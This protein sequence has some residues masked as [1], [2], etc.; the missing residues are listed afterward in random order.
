MLKIKKIKKIAC[1]LM[2]I[3]AIS[4]TGCGSKEEEVVPSISQQETPPVVEEIIPEPEP[5]LTYLDYFPHVDLLGLT[6]DE[7]AQIYEYEENIFEDEVISY[8]LE[9]FDVCN[10][11][12]NVNILTDD[13]DIVNHVEYDYLFG[14]LYGDILDAHLQ[15]SV[16]N[17]DDVFE[18]ILSVD[19]VESTDHDYSVSSVA[20]DF[21]SGKIL[22]GMVYNSSFEVEDVTINLDSMFHTFNLGMVITKYI[23]FESVSVDNA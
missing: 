10:L 9:D 12:Y 11:F 20:D 6:L 1:V 14:N 15:D 16:T 5:V 17:L 3:M 18:L 22:D 4:L 2:S 13:N 23:S 19:A 8:V 21:N 7:V